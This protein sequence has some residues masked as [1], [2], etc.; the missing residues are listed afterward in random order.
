MTEPWLGI[1]GRGPLWVERGGSSQQGFDEI[2]TYLAP[3]SD[4]CRLATR[5]IIMRIW[6]WDDFGVGFKYVFSETVVWIGC[7]D[8]VVCMYPLPPRSD[9]HFLVIS[10][11]NYVSHF[12]ATQVL[13]RIVTSIET[14]TGRERRNTK[15]M[16]QKKHGSFNPR[17]KPREYYYLLYRRPHKSTCSNFREFSRITRVLGA[18][19]TRTAFGPFR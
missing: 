16:K 12:W 19:I 18:F 1:T 8:S 2:W 10:R 9:W 17:R 11:P 5:R 13:V 3:S 4:H 14:E 7:A 15:K 6:L